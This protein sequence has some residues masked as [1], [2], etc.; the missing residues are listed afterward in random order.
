MDTRLQ[1]VILS[2][3]LFFLYKFRLTIISTYIIHTHTHIVCM[4]LLINVNLIHSHWIWQWLLKVQISYPITLT[5]AGWVGSYSSES[6]FILC[7]SFKGCFQEAYQSSCCETEGFS[8]SIFVFT[9]H[10]RRWVNASSCC[11]TMVVTWLTRIKK[12]YLPAHY[13][14]LSK[15]LL[16]IPIIIAGV[17]LAVQK[18][19]LHSF[20]FL[21]SQLEEGIRLKSEIDEGLLLQ[22][23]AE[24]PSILVPLS[25]DDQVE[26]C[27]TSSIY[28]FII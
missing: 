17:A 18:E 19:S 9:F 13:P 10:R 28:F 24:F 4:Y 6:L 11:D 16:T 1:H 15:W 7:F 14:E 26:L 8:S 3:P 25:S 23:P 22:L 21:C 27:N 5:L 2:F 20:A 12:G